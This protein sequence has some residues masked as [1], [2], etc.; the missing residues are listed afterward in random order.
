MFIFS[1]I[2]NVLK[3]LGMFS[4]LA[5]P[6]RYSLLLGSLTCVWCHSELFYIEVVL[7]DL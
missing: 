1:G 2:F 6:V 7:G 5:M 3:G 4:I